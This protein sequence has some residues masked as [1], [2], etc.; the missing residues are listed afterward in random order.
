AKEHFQRAVELNPKSYDATIGLGIAMRG[1]NDLDGAEAAYKKAMSIDPQRGDAY[2]N[3]GVLY[4]DFRANKQ[5]DPDQIK[6]LRMSVQ[7]YKQAK[8]FFNQ[9][10]NKQG[11]QA[12]KN[13]AKENIKDCDKVIKQLEQ[14][15]DMLAK[16]PQQPQGN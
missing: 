16:Q 2:F 14:F 3:L 1:L 7:V 4:K 13:E 15:A 5:N 9:F 12:D 11:S 6:A 10:L 8:E